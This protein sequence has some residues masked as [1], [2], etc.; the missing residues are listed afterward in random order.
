MKFT[1]KY[2]IPIFNFDTKQ[3][4]DSFANKYEIDIF[5]NGIADFIYNLPNYSIKGQLWGNALAK[6]SFIVEND[7]DKWKILKANGW[8]LDFENKQIVLNSV[9][10]YTIINSNN[11]VM[12]LYLGDKDNNF[13]NGYYDFKKDI[14]T[15]YN[16]GRL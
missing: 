5:V 12:G 3:E 9:Y 14:T 6:Q 1:S 2:G 11:S 7:F 15:I 4:Q 13:I 10:K 16:I 8:S